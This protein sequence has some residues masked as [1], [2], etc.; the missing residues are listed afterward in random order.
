MKV[1]DLFYWIAAIGVVIS[2][3]DKE[4]SL[5]FETFGEF[6]LILYYILSFGVIILS[7]LESIWDN[8]N[9]KIF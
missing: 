5:D 7:G 3:F 8:W 1:K 2:L 9:K 4:K 6:L